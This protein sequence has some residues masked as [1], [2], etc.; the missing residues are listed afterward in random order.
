MLSRRIYDPITVILPGDD[1]VDWQASD[2]QAYFGLDGDGKICDETKLRFVDGTTPSRF[3]L[4]Q[5]T[6]R[7][8]IAAHAF[9]TM[10]F[11]QQLFAVRCAL[12]RVS[13]YEVSGSPLGEP[14]R[15]RDGDLGELVATEWILDKA[16]LS[17]EDVGALAIAA[18][19]ISENKRPLLRALG[20]LYGGRA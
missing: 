15:Q 5:L 9:D 8:R 18:M 6:H 4:R 3:T 2:V 7:Q 10:S 11:G 13:G 17:Y 20:S 12:L 1:A 14:D 19:A 16:R